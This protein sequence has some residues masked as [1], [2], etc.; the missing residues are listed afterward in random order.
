MCSSDLLEATESADG[1]HLAALED[2][3][4]ISK[5][6][7]KVREV[8]SLD[9][10]VVKRL[11]EEEPESK[12]LQSEPSLLAESPF[13][14]SPFGSSSG[15]RKRVKSL[16]KILSVQDNL[17][18]MLATCSDIEKDNLYKIEVEMG[19]GKRV[20]GVKVNTPDWWPDF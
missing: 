6:M 2:G 9:E 12:K 14:S 3:S 18:F 16:G 13:G 20:I 1:I 11:K 4:E 17:G 7:E 15:R 10:I 5:I 19:S 8:G